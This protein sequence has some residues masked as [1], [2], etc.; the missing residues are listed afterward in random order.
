[1]AQ[2]V[3][4]LISVKMRVQ[5]LAFLGGLGE[6]LIRP[7]AQELPN[8]AGVAQKRQKIGKKKKK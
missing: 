8:A 5:S 6:A 4:N 7:Q 1:M 3:T 2:W